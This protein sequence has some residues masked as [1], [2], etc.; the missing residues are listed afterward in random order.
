MQFATSFPT[1]VIDGPT[2]QRFDVASSVRQGVPMHNRF[3]HALAGDA[4]LAGLWSS[5]NSSL[6]AEILAY[7]GAD[8]VLIDM[9]H[10]PADVG[11]VMIQLQAMAAAPAAALVR[12]PSDDPVVMKRVLDIGADNVLV[13]FVESAEQAARVVA[14]TRYAPAGRRGLAT[15]TRAG[16]FGRNP[17]YLA[18]AAGAICVIVQIETAAAVAAASAIAEIEGVDALFVGPADLAASMGHIGRPDHPEVVE[19]IE[20][21]LRV[22]ADAK[23]PVG[24][25]AASSADARSRFAQGFRF[26]A[27]SADVRLLVQGAEDALRT[28]RGG[29][30]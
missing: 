15:A 23:K 24:F 4:P 13:P 10:G 17:D 2:G 26:V 16:R 14:A 18:Q 6:V 28:A 30:D 7:S 25:F 19:A 11:D 22:A 12:V 8:W 20:S 21:V 9:E 27:V 3:K 1:S 29:V 5:L